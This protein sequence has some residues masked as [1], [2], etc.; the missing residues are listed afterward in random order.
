MLWVT[1]RGEGAGPIHA[2]SPAWILGIS[3]DPG[4]GRFWDGA[5][6]FESTRYQPIHQNRQSFW[7]AVLGSAGFTLPACPAAGVPQD[8]LASSGPD[9][10]LKRIS[11]AG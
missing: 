11:E 2:L 1:V 7:E 6:E 10:T 3:I 4:A 8:P 9:E 5:G